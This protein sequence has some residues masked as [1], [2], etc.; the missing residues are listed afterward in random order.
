MGGGGT[1]VASKW[2][3]NSNYITE[4]EVWVQVGHVCRSLDGEATESGCVNTVV[5]DGILII[6]DYVS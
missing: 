1:K 4:S 6:S 2:C 3:T 5:A